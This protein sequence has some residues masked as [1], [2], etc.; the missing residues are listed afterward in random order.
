[1]HLYNVGY[2]GILKA[3]YRVFPLDVVFM[4]YPGVLNILY[5]AGV[6]AASYTLVAISQFFRLSNF[7]RVSVFSR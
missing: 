5:A 7:I 1:M 6:W 2:V 4:A 3:L